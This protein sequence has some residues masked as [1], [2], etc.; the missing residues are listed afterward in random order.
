MRK[1]RYILPI[2]AVLI[3]ILSVHFIIHRSRLQIIH[4]IDDT[5][6][7]GEP[8]VICNPFMDNTYLVS[9]DFGQVELVTRSFSSVDFKPLI[10]KGGVITFIDTLN[11]AD[12]PTTTIRKILLPDIFIEGP[13]IIEIPSDI[14]KFEYASFVSIY[15]SVLCDDNGYSIIEF[16]EYEI[17]TG[18]FMSNPPWLNSDEHTGH[19]SVISVDRNVIASYVWTYGN[20]KRAV[21]IYDIEK[22][23]WIKILDVN[24]AASLS[25]SPDGAI[26]GVELTE[27]NPHKI[28]FVDTSNSTLIHEVNEASRAIIGERWVALR[29]RNLTGYILIDMENNWEEKRIDV[30]LHQFDVY[31]I[32][33]PPGGGTMR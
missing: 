31:T 11:I 6:S 28:Q 14:S 32:W 9:F 12:S 19:P 8:I 4:M 15:K 13:I 18:Q 22:G 25:I 2:I 21:W 1:F 29:D 30:P 17:S 5:G 10:S 16:P 26:V 24:G 7:K 33:V 23:E 27:S 20:P 3:T